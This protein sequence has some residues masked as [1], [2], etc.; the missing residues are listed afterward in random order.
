MAVMVQVIYPKYSKHFNKNADI[1]STDM[2]ALCICPNKM[3]N[4]YLSFYRTWDT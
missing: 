3:Y 4:I 2:I 1:F